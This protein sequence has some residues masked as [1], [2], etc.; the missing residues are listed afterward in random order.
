MKKGF[1]YK[2]KLKFGAKEWFAVIITIILLTDITI[3]LNIPFLRQIF[4]FLCF[5]ILPGALILVILKLNNIE[6]LEKVVL[7]VGLS[8]S[9]LTFFGL[10]IDKLYYSLGYLTPLS[11]VSMVVSFSCALI[12]LSI[13]GYKINGENVVT[14]ENIHLTAAEKAFLIVPILFPGLSVFG[15]HLMNITNNNTILVFLLFLIPIYVVF[16]CI[17]NHKF[18]KRLYPVVIFLISISLLLLLSLRSNYILGKDVHMEYH[19]FRVIFSNLHWY[20]LGHSTLDACLAI[21]LL[22]SIYQSFLNVSNSVY[23]YKIFYSLLLSVAPLIVFLISKKY[24]GELYAFLASFFFISQDIFL[25]TAYSPRTNT[26]FLFFGFAMLVF[27]SDG[28]DPL[29]KRL[30]FIVFMASCIVS[31]YATTYIFFFIMLFSWFLIEILSKR[32][33]IKKSISLTLV[34]LFFGIVFFWYSQV[35]EEAFNEGVGFVDATFKNLHNFFL[36]E[37]RCERTQAVLGEGILYGENIR[38]AIPYKIEFVV[39]WISFLLIGAGVI[40]MLTKYKSIIAI[41]EREE[42]HLKPDFLKTK[43]SIEHLVL[44]L[45]CTGILVI[46]VALPYVSEGYDI[47]RTYSMLLVI[48]S[49]VFVL[50][51][52]MLKETLGKLYQL[53]LT[54]STRLRNNKSKQTHNKPEQTLATP[55]AYLIILLVL[56]PLFLCVTGAMFAIFGVPREITLSTDGVNYNTLYIHDQESYSASW[57][58]DFM[59]RDNP[60][61]YVDG[62]G[63]MRLYNEEVTFIPEIAIYSFC[64][65]K[66]IGGNVYLGYR[67]I[68]KGK[69]LCESMECN[70]TDY[71]DVFADKSRIYDNGGSEVW[72]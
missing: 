30:L 69:V 19:F 15:M 22:P 44:T 50:G 66:N 3:L 24:V 16:V 55:V 10:I 72:R 49:V 40:S 54:R 46:M 35:T 57:L 34:L 41:P 27:L 1:Y 4:G 67:N 20:V 51:C 17:F 12:L 26:A 18:P 7:S 62:W 21:S 48:L 45:M 36:F 32:F 9:F 64:G 23:F 33:T 13:L 5:T 56:I 60:R 70:L 2:I 39:T 14:L 25:D 47:K 31:H 37:S 68:I 43:F 59:N 63:G 52:L 53:F 29:R 71:S 65:H 42:E 11:T 61:I 8:I 6:I 38:T 28:I 58:R